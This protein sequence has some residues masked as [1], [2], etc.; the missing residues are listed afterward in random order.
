MDKKCT[1]CE[2]F[3]DVGEFTKAKNQ[4]SGLRPECKAC[5]RAYRETRKEKRAEYN[6]KYREAHKEEGREY[7]KAWQEKNREKGQGYARRYREKYKDELRFRR[8][9]E[10][11]RYDARKR[12]HF[13]CDA[14][15]EEIEA[16]FTGRCDVCSVPEIECNQKLHM[17]HDHSRETS[18]FRGWLC[19]QCN[20]M[21]GFARDSEDILIDALHYLMSHSPK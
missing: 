16:A 20:L 8:I 18:N 19:K 14:S 10:S 7:R 15:L 11:S 4:K 21:I 17:D 9:L 12:G 1:K 6:R 2:E 13:P 3:K 5:Q